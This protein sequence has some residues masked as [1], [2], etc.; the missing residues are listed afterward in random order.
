[1]KRPVFKM[2]AAAQGT[3]RLHM[4]GHKGTLDPHDM[5]ELARTDDLY[6]PADGIAEA[7]RLAAQAFGAA[8]T[9]MLTGGSTAGILAMILS[10]VSPG[11][12]LLLP[13]NVHHAAVSACVWGDV[14]AVFAENMLDAI[15][16][17][18]GAKA[19]FVTRP[20]YY[21]RCL[22]LP[23]IVKSAHAAGMLVLVDE[24]H[25]AH[26]AW[27]EGP[28]SA[29]M[30]GADAWVQSAHKTL[31]ALT[32]TA[33]LHLAST[34]DAGRARRFLRMVQTSSPPFPL[35]QSLDDAR[36]WM[37]DFGPGALR[38]LLALLADVRAAIN[39]LGGYAIVPADDPTRLVI[40]TR[41]RGHSGL[42]VQEML[43]D[44]LVDVEMADDDCV[45]CI[46]TVCD[47]RETFDRL[48]AALAEIPQGDPLLLA[49]VIAPTPGPRRLSVRMAALARQEPVP[50][51][52]AAGRIAAISAGLYPPGIPLVLPGEQVT[53]ACIQKLLETTPGRRFGIEDGCLICVTE[54]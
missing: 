29:G 27:W 3:T 44:Q 39:G 42:T 43:S 50:L 20:D 5:T 15:Q 16:A 18:P 52:Q 26:F 22:D 8:H 37:D 30:L 24:A 40:A 1:M 45:V 51:A 36:A 23:A 9:L 54:D 12:T 53:D 14:D 11:E 41:G 46:C 6:A 13:R 31:P 47:T 19:V 38:T 28:R 10:A 2:L 17:N 49:Q 32:G 7:E 4:P 33:W 34:L 21:G 25:G 48:L 35:L